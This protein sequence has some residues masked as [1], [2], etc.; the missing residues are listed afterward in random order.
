M[1][2]VITDCDHES[3][4]PESQVAA[5]AGI[6]LILA[7]AHSEDEVIQAAAHADALAVQY[8]PIT[9]KV[10]TALPN[11]KAVGRYGVG[12][13]T[14]DVTAATSHRFGSSP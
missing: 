5:A 10:L 2:I 13:D 7:D 12:V 1:Q 6:E 3:I 8:A 11:L 4:E 14:V 9:R